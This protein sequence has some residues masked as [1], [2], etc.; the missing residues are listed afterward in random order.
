MMDGMTRVDLAITIDRPVE[1]VFRVLTDP[2]TT[3]RR[4]ANAIE[5]HVTTAGPVE[6]GSRRRATVRRFGGGAAKNEIEVTALEPNRRW[7]SGASS[8]RCPSARPMR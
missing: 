8:R 4:S 5:E 2:S 6:V 3:A 1:D 7:R